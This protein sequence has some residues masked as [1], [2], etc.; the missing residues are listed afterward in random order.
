MQIIM[1]NQFI[2][3]HFFLLYSICDFRLTHI[4]IAA[5]IVA[6]KNYEKLNFGTSVSQLLYI[7]ISCVT[8]SI[9]TSTWQSSGLFMYWFHFWTSHWSS[10]YDWRRSH[11]SPWCFSHY[12]DVTGLQ[13]TGLL[14][15][16]QHSIT[17]FQWVIHISTY[18]GQISS[19]FVVKP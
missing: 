16:G 14:R 5:Q 11:V 19:D 18:I 13:L 3:F 1:S 4:L 8:V 7:G 15:E 9:S 6:L 12:I 17:H 10:L 2:F